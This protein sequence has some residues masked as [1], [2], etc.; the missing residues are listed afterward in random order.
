M[1]TIDCTIKLSDVKQLCDAISQKILNDKVVGIYLWGV[2][3]SFYINSKKEVKVEWEVKTWI[4]NE[5]RECCEIDYISFSELLNN[6]EE[7]DFIPTC[8][9]LVKCCERIFYDAYHKNSS[10]AF[11]LKFMMDK[12]R[13]LGL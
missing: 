4:D 5:G 3:E 2:W 1:S 10:D 6:L 13:R 11:P 7:K 9:Y 8:E 12:V